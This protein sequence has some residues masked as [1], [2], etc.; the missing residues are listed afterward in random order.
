M[1][2]TPADV[3]AMQVADEE[4]IKIDGLELQALYTPGHTHRKF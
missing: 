2:Q 1:T 3:V 4:T